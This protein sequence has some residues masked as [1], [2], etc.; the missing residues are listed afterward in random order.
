MT[1]RSSSSSTDLTPLAEILDAVLRA[2]Q[3]IRSG[4]RT[5]ST[6]IWEVLSVQVWTGP[7]YSWMRPTLS[8]QWRYGD[9]TPDTPTR[10]E[11]LSMVQELLVSILP[12]Y[13]V[14]ISDDREVLVR[15]HGV[16]IACVE[17]SGTWREPETETETEDGE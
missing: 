11:A 4:Q 13:L 5:V 9:P 15:Q 8:L 7:G 10:G 14:T 1:K 2:D 3:Q 17:V 6:Q 12:D 16:R